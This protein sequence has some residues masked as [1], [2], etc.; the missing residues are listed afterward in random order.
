MDVPLQSPTIDWIHP[1]SR[2]WLP[3][4]STS[5]TRWSTKGDYKNISCLKVG[6]P[7]ERAH[8]ESETQHEEDNVQ[9]VTIQDST[10]LL[11]AQSVVIIQPNRAFERSVFGDT[12]KD[13][14]SWTDLFSELNSSPDWRFL[15]IIRAPTDPPKYNT[16]PMRYPNGKIVDCIVS[17][18]ITPKNPEIKNTNPPI[19]FNHDTVH[20]KLG[21]NFQHSF[22]YIAI[23]PAIK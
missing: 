20:A 18:G 23:A 9:H 14:I 2:A 21:F 13:T 12:F 16:D 5:Q 1:V 6:D 22:K 11:V 15:H 8:E 10:S 17:P 19:P 7:N 4:Q 3:S